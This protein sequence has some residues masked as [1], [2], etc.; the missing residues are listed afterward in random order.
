M[1][2]L[3]IVSLI[4]TLLSLFFWFV[5]WL[6]FSFLIKSYSYNSPLRF[7]AQ[8]CTAL[9]AVTEYLAIALLCIGLILISKNQLNPKR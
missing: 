3:G 8:S 1:R 5:S 6:Y 2:I 9:S 4:L 7:V